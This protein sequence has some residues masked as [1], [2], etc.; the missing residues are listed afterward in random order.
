VTRKAESRNAYL[1]N[2]VAT[3]RFAIVLKKSFSPDKGKFLG[4]LVRFA[5]R[6][7]G[8]HHH[9]RQKR[10]PARVSALGSFAAIEAA[11]IDFREIWRCSIFDFCNSIRQKQ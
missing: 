9:F 7:E 2:D 11:K 8:P 3:G 10:P 5:R 1:W 6:R 4:P